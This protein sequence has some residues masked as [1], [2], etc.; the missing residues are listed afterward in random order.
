LV[1]S[2]RLI[3]RLFSGRQ[4]MPEFGGILP[5]YTSD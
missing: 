3:L 1:R 5:A 4:L 2:E